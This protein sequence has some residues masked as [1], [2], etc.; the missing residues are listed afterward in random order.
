MEHI[1]LK[2]QNSFDCS[3]EDEDEETLDDTKFGN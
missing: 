2:K 1:K 3:M